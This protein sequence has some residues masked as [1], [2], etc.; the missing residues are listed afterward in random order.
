MTFCKLNVV[1]NSKQGVPSLTHVYAA[2]ILNMQKTC[3]ALQFFNAV[4]QVNCNGSCI[5]IPWYSTVDFL[6]NYYSIYHLFIKTK[7]K[8]TDKEKECKQNK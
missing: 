7:N 5:P 3:L 1:Q 4:Q 2:T 8:G 6:P